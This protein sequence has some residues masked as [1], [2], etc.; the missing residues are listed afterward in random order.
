MNSNDSFSA[1]PASSEYADYDPR[2]YGFAGTPEVMPPSVRMARIL[3]WFL[4]TL[5]LALIGVATI[6]GNPDLGGAIAFGYLF[7]WLLGG[8]AFAFGMDGRTVQVVGVVLAAIS[9]FLCLGLMAVG[10]L[11]GLTGL[12]LSFAVIVLLCKR[13]STVWFLRHRSTT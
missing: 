7:A 5:G 2:H 9:G 11:P 10:P 13:E 12:C 8:V 6:T 4:A 3:S 1:D